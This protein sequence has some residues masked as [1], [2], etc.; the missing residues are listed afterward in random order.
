VSRRSN[1]PIPPEPIAPGVTVA[2][3]AN[4]IDGAVTITIPQASMMFDVHIPMKD[5]GP[6]Q[7]LVEQCDQVPPLQ[8]LG[9]KVTNGV[10][11]VS[12]PQMQMELD[13]WVEGK[14]LRLGKQGAPAPATVAPTGIASELAQGEWAFA[15]F[16]RGT[17]LGEGQFPSMPMGALPDEAKMGLRVMMFLNEIGLGVR[18]DGDTVRFLASART[19]WSNPDDVVAKIVAI[20]PDQIVTGK[21]AGAAKEIANSA[22]NSPFAGDFKAGLGGVMIPA[23]SVGILA[24]V[25]IPA[26]LDY[27]RKAKAIRDDVPTMPDGVNDLQGAPPPPN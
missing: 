22:P 16:G 27:Q 11:H 21:A 13:A 6:A 24:A 4:N 7:K 10:C 2:D 3:L 8:M 19:A 23:A 17:L 15:M 25:A 9:A 20:P 12:V 14:E 18:A 5:T 1:A 26:F